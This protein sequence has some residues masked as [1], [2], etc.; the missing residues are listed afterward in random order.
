MFLL[1]LLYILNTTILCASLLDHIQ[2]QSV[3]ASPL[4]L[5]FSNSGWSQMTVNF[6][7]QLEDVGV[8]CDHI[9][10]YGWDNATC[11]EVDSF[12]GPGNC[13][14]MDWSLQRDE[15]RILSS[16]LTSK[17]SLRAESWGTTHYMD[18]INSRLHVV[19]YLLDH[20]PGL[21]VWLMDTDAALYQNP[22]F[23]WPLRAHPRRDVWFQEEYPG[24]SATQRQINGGCYLLRSNSRTLDLIERSIEMMSRLK[25]PDQD[26][27][28]LVLERHPR[29]VRDWGFFPLEDFP[30]GFYWFYRGSEFHHSNVG[31]GF[32]HP[33]AMPV[34]IHANWITG[35]RGKVQR[36][37]MLGKWL[38][39]HQDNDDIGED[40]CD[41][42][43]DLRYDLNLST[44]V[45]TWRTATLLVDRSRLCAPAY[46]RCGHF[47]SFEWC[48]TDT[49]FAPW[50]TDYALDLPSETKRTLLRIKDSLISD[51]TRNDVW[52]YSDVVR[53]DIERAWIHLGHNTDDGDSRHGY[54]C[55]KLNRVTFRESQEKIPRKFNRPT[56]VLW[57]GGTTFLDRQERMMVHKHF[58]KSSSS[59]S[60]QRIVYAWETLWFGMQKLGDHHDLPRL[61]INYV[62]EH[63]VKIMEF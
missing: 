9:L 47:R 18:M 7:R 20:V 19:R 27:I 4:I 36:L 58:G 37:R 45:Q 49:L 56:Y 30:N 46:Y 39:I 43:L 26:A 44:V 10:V 29:V 21:D 55:V 57:E 6:L 24:K 59:S 5:L 23:Y 61:V 31:V 2:E 25:L 50:V 62:C 34:Y 33:A 28:Q 53:N 40:D 48:S 16:S 12:M 22:L 35:Y 63:A 41:V 11:H 17:F 54:Y 32:Y 60:S 52:I 51:E 42:S 13:Y 8:A 14:S 3:V 38:M 1:I 15:I